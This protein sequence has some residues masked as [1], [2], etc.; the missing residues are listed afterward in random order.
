MSASYCT[1]GES[2]G[3][4]SCG[5]SPEERTSRISENS[6]PAKFA[7]FHFYNVGELGLL[8]TSQ[9]NH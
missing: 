9:Q 8:G 6:V 3:A 7:E 2:P 1:G 5:L 4:A